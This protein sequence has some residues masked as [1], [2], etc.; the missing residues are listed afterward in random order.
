MTPSL[1]D[2]DR[3][4]V[5]E[6]SFLIVFRDGTSAW[7]IIEP[8][9]PGAAPARNTR[10]S[11]QRYDQLALNEADGFSCDLKGFVPFGKINNGYMSVMP[12]T[13]NEGFL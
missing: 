12:V 11:S 1:S 2:I 13:F 3:N 10:C 8:V 5:V 6:M 4:N 9:D 7:L